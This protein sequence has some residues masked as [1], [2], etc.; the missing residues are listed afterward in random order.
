MR[1]TCPRCKGP[2]TVEHL[3]VSLDGGHT[4]VDQ[5][6]IKCTRFKDRCKATK[7]TG[8]PATEEKK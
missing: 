8:Q 5:Q 7:V 4:F 1:P 2:A 3:R 6:I